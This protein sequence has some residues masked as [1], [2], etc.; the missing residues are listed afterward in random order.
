MLPQRRLGI[1][2]IQLL[3]PDAFCPAGRQNRCVSPFGCAANL[4]PERFQLLQKALI[5]ACF[6]HGFLHIL[7]HKSAQC[8][9]ALPGCL[10][11]LS[12]LAAAVCFDHR[13]GILPAQFIRY[14]AD[15]L[16]VG[17]IVIP[18][19]PPIHKTH[20]VEYDVAVQMLPIQ[21]GTD[22][23]L[24]PVCQKPASKFAADL[25]CLLWCGFAWP[26]TLNDVI[27]Q[28]TAAQRFSPP[29][30]CGPHCGKGVCRI[31][32]KASHIQLPFC[33]FSVLCIRQKPLHIFCRKHFGFFRVRRITQATIQMAA[34]RNNFGICHLSSEKEKQPCKTRLPDFYY[35]STS[36]CCINDDVRAVQYPYLALIS[37][38]TSVASSKSLWFTSS[39]ASN[40]FA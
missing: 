10:P 17:F 32:V 26:K 25:K 34:H 33:F 9:S 16:V 8:R 19:H 27:S 35:E 1:P 23:T 31:T 5:T 7:T 29:A 30:L 28:H 20:R 40:S 14:S 6:Q 22:R 38:N 12:C 2:A 39:S 36:I 24:K 18:E 11:V 15:L 3:K 4:I 21:M 37:E 13:Q